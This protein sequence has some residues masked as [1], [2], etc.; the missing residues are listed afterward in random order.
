[1]TDLDAAVF[2]RIGELFDAVADLAPDQQSLMLQDLCPDP[3]LREQVQALLLADQRGQIFEDSA[4]DHLD[5]LLTTENEGFIAAGTR[6]GAWCVD[7]E[8]GRGGMGVVYRVDRSEGGFRQRGALKLI[9]RGMDSEAVLARFLREREALA[10]LEHSGIA[11]LLDGGVSDDGRP[12]LVME[13]VEGVP[14][15]QYVCAHPGLRERLELFRQICAAVAYAHRRLV[16]HRDIKPSNVLVS[17]EG[18]CKLLDFGIAKLLDE[19]IGSTDSTAT[20]T[21]VFTPDYA[22]P[23]QRAG[24]PVGTPVDVYALGA[25]LN[26][27]LTG[28]RLRSFE[29]IAATAG[30][31]AARRIEAN[32]A[33]RPGKIVA[34]ARRQLRGDLETIVLRA[35][36]SDPERRYASVDAL[37]EDIRRHIV[38]QPILA[39]R[40]H[41][42]YQFG[43]FV[44]RHRYALSA[45]LLVVAVSIIAALVSLQQA[46]R[47]REQ[48]GRAETVK[49]FLTGVFEQASPDEN[50]GQPFTARQLLERGEKQSTRLDGSPSE[51]VEIASLL[52]R[53]YWDIGDFDRALAIAEQAAA[54]ADA[55]QIPPRVHAEAL[56]ALARVENELRRFPSAL[57]HAGKA[58]QILGALDPDEALDARRQT[59]SILLRSEDYLRAEPMLHA[60][61]ADERKRVGGNSRAVANDLIMLATLHYNNGQE[62][63]AVNTVREAIAILKELPRTP[64]GDMLEAQTRLGLSQLH[65][66]HFEEAESALRDADEIATRIYG[67]DNVQT[68]TTRSNVIRVLELE[69]RLEQ[70]IIE[71]Q[72]L[73]DTQRKALGESNPA[74]LAI[75]SKFLAADY[76]DVSRFREAEALFRE[77][78]RLTRLADGLEN[79]PD[80][81][82]TLLNLGYT[83][84][85]QGRYAEAQKAMD[86]SYAILKAHSAT[87]SQWLNDARGRTNG[88]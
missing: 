3:S 35:T 56:L 46:E 80:S 40:D 59:V 75:H 72:N 85:L 33:N 15:E 71:R 1:M 21:R 49:R 5:E 48:A 42:F 13:Y 58:T 65:L 37:D 88:A 77:S 69:G 52:A 18:Q 67:A 2:R 81:V 16:V 36:D 47:A 50:G 53:L 30:P 63:D 22:A 29:D 51:R 55:G 78:L 62:Q 17:A 10:R 45:A 39:R 8:I 64:P 79:G 28:A 83:L 43:K 9:K 70:A 19:S 73:L 14:L 44:S 66:Y 32:P 87:S 4:R 84:Q 76:R 74:Q 38:G 34:L 31:R 24:G 57:D 11:R 7:C 25:L 27:I 6:F 86:S 41:A 23:E 20:Q 61:L 54:P 82:D 26:L 60:L 12:F 68:W